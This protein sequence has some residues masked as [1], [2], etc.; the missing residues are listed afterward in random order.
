MSSLNVPGVN[1]FG[2]NSIKYTGT[3]LWNNLYLPN[4]Q[5]HSTDDFK[6]S[7]Q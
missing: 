6:K 4:K 7:S 1:G 2:E 5:L 3:R